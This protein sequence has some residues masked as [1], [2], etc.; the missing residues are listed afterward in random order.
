M[1]KYKRSTGVLILLAISVCAI[2]LRH[3][4]GD[5]GASLAREGRGARGPDIDK[6]TLLGQFDPTSS[7]GFVQAQTPHASRAGLYLLGEVYDAFIQM[8]RAARA[9]GISLVIV[10]ATRNFEDQKRIWEGKWTGQRLVND[11]NLAQTVLDPA[12]RARVILKYSSMPGT[13]RHHWG[14]DIDIN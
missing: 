5:A 9:D 12:Q 3:Y 13:S 8:H 10:S 7:K 1:M 2:S 14:T 4:M 6:K 11:R